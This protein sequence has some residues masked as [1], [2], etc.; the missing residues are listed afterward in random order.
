MLTHS[1]FLVLNC[2][3]PSVYTVP[4][5]KLGSSS[6][7]STVCLPLT[8]L[9]TSASEMNISSSVSP[10]SYDPAVAV[11][12]V[13]NSDAALNSVIILKTKKSKS[14]FH[15]SCYLKGH[16]CTTKVAAIVTIPPCRLAGDDDRSWLID[17]RKCTQ[18][19]AHSYKEEDKVHTLVRDHMR[20]VA[21]VAD[22]E[23]DYGEDGLMI[24][25]L[26]S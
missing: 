18:R 17:L 14:H 23:E 13:M 21:G 26:V 3:I 15:I 16:H 7:D 1:D 4:A 12:Q 20:P 11:Q 22:E 10:V 24:G 9:S 19:I 2:H 5:C 25:Q 8:P 6:V